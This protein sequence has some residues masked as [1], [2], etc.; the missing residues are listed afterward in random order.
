MEKNVHFLEHGSPKIHLINCVATLGKCSQTSFPRP[1]VWTLMAVM[2]ELGQFYPSTKWWHMAA[3]HYLAP[4]EVGKEL[5]TVVIFVQHFFILYF[6][7][8]NSS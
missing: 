1:F 6:L 2:L 3:K 4:S 8:I 7:A 5:L